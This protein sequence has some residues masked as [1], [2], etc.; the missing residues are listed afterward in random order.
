MLLLFSPILGKLAWTIAYKVPFRHNLL[1]GSSND[2]F[3]EMPKDFGQGMT[4][5]KEYLPPT[6]DLYQPAPM[7]PLHPNAVANA[8]INPWQYPAMTP[9]GQLLAPVMMDPNQAGQPP[10]Q[11]DYTAM[12]AM[13]G[14]APG[15]YAPAPGYAVYGF[16]PGAEMAYG[17]PPFAA[18]PPPQMCVPGNGGEGVAAPQQQAWQPAFDQSQQFYHFQGPKPQAPGPPAIAYGYVTPYCLNSPMVMPEP[19]KQQTEADPPTLDANDQPK[20]EHDDAIQEEAQ[21]VTE[22]DNMPQQQQQQQVPTSNPTPTF[23]TY[24]PTP[25]TSWFPQATQQIWGPGLIY[26]NS[27]APIQCG[28]MD[29]ASNGPQ[30]TPQAEPWVGMNPWGGFKLSTEWPMLPAPPPSQGFE[31]Q[32]TQ[33]AVHTQSGAMSTPAFSQTP[34]RPTTA[35]GVEPGSTPLVNKCEEGDWTL[36][37]SMTTDSI[38]ANS[39]ENDE[40]G[41]LG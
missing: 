23:L 29:P 5:G 38:D 15:F 22:N 6:C 24:H 37:I 34:R 9:D 26:Q 28:L 17:Y 32:I 31:S 21:A 11:F 13:P 10:P 41:S 4:I 2:L 36:P 20:S 40:T 39:K 3:F 12:A 30:A 35:E 18:P 7:P 1:P 27:P 16:P 33:D 19:P 14:Y 25:L 8:A